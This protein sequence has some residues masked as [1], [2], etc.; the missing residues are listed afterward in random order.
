MSSS[1]RLEHPLSS[2]GG[3]HLP[4]HDSRDPFEAVDDLMQVVEALCPTWP[5][6]AP[7]P[8]SATFIL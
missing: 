8:S 2:E 4:A 5:S 7:F 6:R 3:L 1:E